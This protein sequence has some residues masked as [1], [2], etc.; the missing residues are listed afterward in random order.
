M[1]GLGEGKCPKWVSY[2]SAPVAFDLIHILEASKG[3]P[4]K[5][6][7]SQDASSKPQGTPGPCTCALAPKRAS[8]EHAQIH[9]GARLCACAYSRES[10]LRMCKSCKS[11]LCACA[12]YLFS[13]APLLLIVTFTPKSHPIP[14][15]HTTNGKTIWSIIP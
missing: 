12:V 3:G 13:S 2:L 15:N 9:G 11:R 5:A 7:N 10:R 1:Q 8:P 4:P 6:T 14:G